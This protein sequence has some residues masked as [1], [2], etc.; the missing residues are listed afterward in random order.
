MEC[1]SAGSSA[2]G[3]RTGVATVGMAVLCMLIVGLSVQIASFLV[4]EE[5]SQGGL[6]TWAIGIV[7]ALLWKKDSIDFWDALS[8]ACIC[9]HILGCAVCLISLWFNS[10]DAPEIAAYCASRGSMAGEADDS[11]GQ[12]VWGVRYLFFDIVSNYEGTANGS[13][14][15][16][17]V[18]FSLVVCVFKGGLGA[19][20]TYLIL[21]APL[22]GIVTF[23]A[24]LS[25]KRHSKA[26]RQNS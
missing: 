12:Y 8:L 19:W 11:L 18:A 1:S 17:V 2:T 10:A 23:G 24:W 13:T 20:T 21:S 16:V 25:E 22:W 5:L 6:M 9:G 4:W 15:I 3:G 14:N 7:L 26:E